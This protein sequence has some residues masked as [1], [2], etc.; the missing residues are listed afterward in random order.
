MNAKHLV[1]TCMHAGVGKSGSALDDEGVLEIDTTIT[2][3]TTWRAMEDLVS[4]GLVRS[5]GIRFENFLDSLTFSKAPLMKYLAFLLGRGSSNV[6]VKE[7]VI[8]GLPIFIGKFSLLLYS[9]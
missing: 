9:T 3:E 5:I 4:M 8:Q 6:T 2:L 1:V 7:I